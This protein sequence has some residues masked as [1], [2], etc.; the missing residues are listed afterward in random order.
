VPRDP[1]SRGEQEGKQGPKDF[2][3]E[4][5]LSSSPASLP[6][7]VGRLGATAIVIGTSIGSGIFLVPHDI[8]Q[9]V[10]SVEA[11]LAIWVVGGALSLAGALSIAELGAA[12]PEA[13][14]VYIY[15]RQ[16]YGR[17]FAFLYGW[18][19]LT[20]TESGAIA[21]LA[22]AFGIYSGTFY[23]LT[24]LQRSL[25][26]SLVIALL[27]VV[28]IVGV[29]KGAAVQAVFMAAKLFG[30]SVILGF[31]FFSTG[32]A[33]PLAT[34]PLPTP[35]TT[36]ASFGV[37]LIGALWAYQGWHILSYASGE[38]KDPGRIL[39]WSYLLGTSVVVFV[40]LSSNLAYLRV[41]PL[42][43][44]ADD[45][46]QSVAAK[47]MDILAGPKGAA[48]VSVLILCSI[49][50][51]LNGN[52]LGGGRVCFAMARD[53]VFFPSV[54]RIHPRYETP[55]AALV[56]QGVWSIVLANIGSF[57]QLYTYVITSGW[58]FYGMAALGVLILRRRMPGL[59]RPYRVWGYPV[60]PVV[61]ALVCFVVIGNSLIQT[62]RASLAA[63]GF[64][65]IG[66]PL[67]YAWM[68]WGRSRSAS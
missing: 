12:T 57:R 65:L 22:V 21:T 37:G 63:L 46:Y 58:F 25:I 54:G 9:R 41:L 11:L 42:A 43:V 3:I 20:V 29:K 19:A 13:G 27:T 67:Y 44:L 31:A 49:F 18:A 24:H 55:A 17:L 34:L 52:I 45:R 5:P 39:P 51:A 56:I 2:N 40:Y 23:P 35:H 47:T 16:A 10:G 36:F 66:V 14:G 61:F 8:A 50:G 4:Q 26:S 68:A 1:R 59:E 62:P 48:F 7:A 53:D 15:L 6:R 60:V 64:I 28:N 38:V 30:I 33:R 32:I